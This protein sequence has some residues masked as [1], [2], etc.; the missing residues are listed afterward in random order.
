M[1]HTVRMKPFIKHAA[2]ERTVHGSARTTLRSSAY[3]D[4]TVIVSRTTKSGNDGDRVFLTVPASM[5]S[6]LAKETSKKV[7]ALVATP[8]SSAQRERALELAQKAR[9]AHESPVTA[10]F[11]RVMHEAF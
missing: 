4:G 5:Q 11:R 8:I 7:R 1:S 2:K 6:K 3:A 10:K 9:A